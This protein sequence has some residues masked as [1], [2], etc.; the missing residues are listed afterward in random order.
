VYISRVAITAKGFQ[1]TVSRK[2]YELVKRLFEKECP[3]IYDGTVEIK[4]IAREA[5]SRSKIAV[6]SNKPDVDAVGACVGQNGSRVDAIV[7]ELNGEK[8][9]IIPWSEN[10]A[11]FIEAALRP[12]RVVAVEVDEIREVTEVDE[13]GNETTRTEKTARAVVPDTQLSLAIGKSGQNVRLAAKLT[14]W[15]IDIKSESQ[16]RLTNFID[17]SKIDGVNEDENADEYT[18]EDYDLISEDVDT[19]ADIK[20]YT[21]ADIDADIEAS[22]NADIDADAEA[23]NSEAEN[24]EE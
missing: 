3:E 13:N 17:F 20:V 15:K 23:D 18:D 12:A 21:D 14:G 9:D 4:S 1:I 8:I 6:V 24:I 7:N 11:E 5:G 2:H 19:E 16:A 22:I 10:P